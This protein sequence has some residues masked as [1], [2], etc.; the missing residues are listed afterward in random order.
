M[1]NQ[2]VK[3]RYLMTC[4]SDAAMKK[5]AKLLESEPRATSLI[6]SNANR[7]G[8]SRDA[9]VINEEIRVIS[10]A[11]TPSQHQKVKKSKVCR[12]E[13]D[14][15]AFACVRPTDVRAAVED[16]PYP[17][18]IKKIDADIVWPKT[19]GKG[20]RVAVLDTG[21]DSR[22]RNL[23]A[24]VKRGVSC[25][26]N[27]TSAHDD[28]GHGTHCA[29]IIAANLPSGRRRPNASIYGVAPEASIFPVKVLNYN[30]DG[31]L[32]AILSGLEW[33][34]HNKM[35]IVS[36]SFRIRSDS[37]SQALQQACMTLWQRGL[38][39]VAATGNDRE[40]KKKPGGRSLTVGYPAQYDSVLGIGATDKLDTI[41]P[42]SNT[43]KGV[44]LVAP[45][46]GILS[47]YRDNRY[48]ELSGTSQAC[49][50]VAG[51]AALL[52][53]YRKELSNEQLKMVLL[54]TADPLGMGE[55]DEVYGRGLLNA[56]GAI[57]Q[58]DAILV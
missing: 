55:P 7:R 30:G 58:L 32:S 36:M 15:H 35:D 56:T 18:G 54:G 24:N 3:T 28:N 2:T 37:P 4:A 31:L 39:L 8:V 6:S 46:V 11:L 14:L 10:V 43:G 52:K 45:G 38:L 19:K 47:T 27:V 21:I 29:G 41:A 23:Q 17:W 25:V 26:E 20:V 16:F 57:E 22:H 53:S 1:A 44:D 40:D 50:H 9:G 51:V 13:E 48:R 33:C 34:L 12:I 5:A 42:F 49:P